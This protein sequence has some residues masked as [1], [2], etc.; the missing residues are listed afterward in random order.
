[1]SVIEKRRDIGIIRSMGARGEINYSEYLCLRDLLVG[2]IGTLVR[3][4][5]WIFA[6]CILQI[7]YNIYPLD[8]TQYKIDSLPLE[9][10]Y[11]DFFYVAGMSMFI[12]L[13]CITL[14]ARKAA[15]VNPVEAIK[16][17]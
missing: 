2:I 14:S 8:P 5:S 3:S 4:I 11:T 6:I 10:R 17:E 13:S 12:V 16:W 15:K 7:K 1:M 9:I